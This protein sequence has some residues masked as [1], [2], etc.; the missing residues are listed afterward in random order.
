MPFLVFFTVI[1]LI[2]VLVSIINDRYI[3]IPNEIAILIF[4]L[5][6]SIIL[7]IIDSF[8]EIEWVNSTINSLKDFSFESYLLDGVLCFMLFAGASEVKFNK[9]SQNIKNITILSFVSTAIS[10]FIYGLIFYLFSLL[11]KL[12][13]GLWVCILLGTIIAPT[14]PIAATGILS[15]L[16]M[17]KNLTTVIESE[18]LFNDGMGVILFAF[19]KSIITNIGTNIGIVLIKEIFGAILVASI[20]CFILIL[21][22]KLSK[23][24]IN[25]VL[26][27]VLAVSSS[28]VLCTLFDFSG[29]I[30]SVL[31]GMIFSYYRH[32]NENY[33]SLVDQHNMY[34]SFWRLIDSILNSALFVLI[35]LM[36]FKLDISYILF[37]ISISAILSSFISRFSGVSLPL[38]FFRGR[39]APGGYN[40]LEYSSLMTWCA[41]KGG[42][43]LALV[44]SAQSILSINE[45]TILFSAV[46]ITI[47]FTVIIQGLLTKRV[48]Y[49][50]ERH[51]A[52]RIKK[53][54][55]KE[56]V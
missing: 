35:G 31:C 23:K 55:D 6:M 41:L 37:F 49:G 12:D 47:V 40:L 48:Y 26:I 14:D 8:I 51:K 53:E 10:A 9:F 21:L 46:Y 27:S 17:S 43:S 52:L 11:F 38:C 7:K 56:C 33:F 4:T 13:I 39:R 3:K 20:I 2:V 36:F 28:Y 16:G 45:N 54:S 44:L 18:S 22:M 29:C 19:I 30:A 1:I 15:K 24:P 5:F 50:I 42:L 32:K 25:H 34:E